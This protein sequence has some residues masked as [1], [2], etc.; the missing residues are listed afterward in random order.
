MKWYYERKS[1]E[2]KFKKYFGNVH[3]KVIGFIYALLRIEL[4]SQERH[5]F[6][7]VHW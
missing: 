4:D 3:V 7:S 2:L 1:N 6:L 5:N